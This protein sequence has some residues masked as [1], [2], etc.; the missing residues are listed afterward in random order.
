[1]KSEKPDVI[2]LC[3]AQSLVT[4]T[5]STSGTTLRASR[6][7]SCASVFA[8]FDTGALTLGAGLVS[9]SEAGSA[10]GFGALG[11]LTGV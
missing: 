2:V 1:M 11:F 10:A 3:S 8:A 9:G 4:T 6:T 5:F 7:T